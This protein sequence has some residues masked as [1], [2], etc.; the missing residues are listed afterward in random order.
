MVCNAFSLQFLIHGRTVKSLVH[1][2]R[3]KYCIRIVLRIINIFVKFFVKTNK[4]VRTSFLFIFNAVTIHKLYSF[5]YRLIRIFFSLT[6][7]CV[8]TNVTSNTRFELNRLYYCYIVFKIRMLITT[9]SLFCSLCR[10]C[11]F[12]CYFSLPFTHILN[13]GFRTLS[14]L[15]FFL[16]ILK[17][18]FSIYNE[19]YLLRIF[20]ISHVGMQCLFFLSFFL[21]SSSH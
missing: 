15:L 10:S 4:F 3:L 20:F 14:S 16:S 13:N 19:Q 2:F 12:A 8:A 21:L 18:A 6:L 7:N 5:H 11:Y 17:N 9:I 1:L